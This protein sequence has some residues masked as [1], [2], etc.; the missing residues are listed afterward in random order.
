MKGFG[1]LVL[2]LGAVF[3]MAALVGGD[4]EATTSAPVDRQAEICAESGQQDAYYTSRGLVRQKLKAPSTAEFPNYYTEDGSI[5]VQYL[6]GCKFTIAAWVDSQN[7][8]GAM[9]R[10]PYLVEVEYRPETEDWYGTTL[11]IE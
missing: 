7:S 3:G 5:T 2:C 1:T 9:I 8:F 6:G 10:T 4:D 11:L